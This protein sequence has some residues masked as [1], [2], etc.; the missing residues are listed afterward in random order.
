M[1]LPRPEAVLLLGAFL[2]CP[3]AVAAPPSSA[4][5]HATASSA[6]TD[7]QKGPAPPPGFNVHLVTLANGH[8]LWR[9]GAPRPDTLAALLASAR[10]RGVRVTLLD[11]RHPPFED[12]LSGKGGRLSPDA[13][14]KA[15]STAS[16]RYL[17]MSALDPSLLKQIEEALSEGDVY[18]H[19]MYGVNRTGFAVGRY[20]TARGASVD[21]TGLGERDFN[22]G[23]AFQ[24]AHP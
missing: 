7:T 4:P 14:K 3:P 2:T 22:Q 5:P 9:G 11:L 20:A 8:R 10:A 15:A 23:E 17:S 1:R 16:S 19:C 18:V 12:D 24:R 13:E 21:R 6:S